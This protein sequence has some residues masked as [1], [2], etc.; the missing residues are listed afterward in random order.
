MWHKQNPQAHCSK[1]VLLVLVCTDLHRLLSGSPFLSSDAHSALEPR[2]HLICA[3]PSSC[4]STFCHQKKGTNTIYVLL[5]KSGK[6][7]SMKK[8]V[9]SYPSKY[10]TK[11]RSNFP[12]YI[13]SRESLNSHLKNGNR[14]TL[15]IEPL[16]CLF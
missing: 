13:K 11:H 4:Q 15:G 8:G 7:I 14:N 12:H 9:R 3:K 16:I 5:V 2:R 6:T 10:L 1:R